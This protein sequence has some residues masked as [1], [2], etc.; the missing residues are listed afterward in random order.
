MVSNITNNG[1]NNPHGGSIN[2]LTC[3]Q[4]GRKTGFANG[5]SISCDQVAAEHLGTETRF[6]SLVLAGNESSKGNQLGHDGGL[7]LSWNRAG[8]P[9]PAVDKPM[10]LYRH[11]FGVGESP[12]KLKARLLKKQSILDIVKLDSSSLKRTLSNHDQQKLD[13]YFTGVRQLERGLER[14]AEWANKPLPRGLYSAPDVPVDGEAEIRMM[15]DMIIVALQ[16]DSTRVASYR[17]PVKSV[18]AGLKLTSP[19]ALSHYKNFKKNTVA[20]Q[21]RDEILMEQFAHFLDR[22]K[23]A[24]DVDGSRLY[25]NCIVSF[26]TNLR[27]G[28]VLRGMPAILSGGGAKDIKHGRHIV[29]PKKD[30]RLSNYW[31]TL[32]Q[33]ADIPVSKFSSSTGNIPELLS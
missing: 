14:Q 16:T 24:K 15:Y 17:L 6:P 3:A 4:T 28:H 19:H 1:A 26:G 32:L 7:S 20:S 27:T 31:L 8:D 2:Y 12:E 11:L 21:R 30:T 10:S 9:M 23:E 22:L 18:V 5:S 25:D 33:Q 13:E 29:L